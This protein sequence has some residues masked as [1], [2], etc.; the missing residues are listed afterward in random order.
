MLSVKILIEEF[1]NLK[2]LATMRLKIV[3]RI[4]Q[5]NIGTLD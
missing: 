4:Q 2:S 3:V 5:W 1:S